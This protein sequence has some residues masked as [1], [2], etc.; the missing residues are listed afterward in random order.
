MNFYTPL[1]CRRGIGVLGLCIIGIMDLADSLR[2]LLVIDSNGKRYVLAKA[3]G[4]HDIGYALPGST[5][6]ADEQGFVHNAFPV[7]MAIEFLQSQCFIDAVCLEG[8]RLF[9]QLPFPFVQVRINIVFRQIGCLLA[10]NAYQGSCLGLG[11]KEGAT[12]ND[13][14]DG[15]T[16]EYFFPRPFMFLDAVAFA[17]ATAVVFHSLFSCFFFILQR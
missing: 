14:E 9:A 12:A 1:A 8:Q 7:E 4:L 11:S 17:I 15:Y 5:R 13:T 6:A 10:V 2:Q 3:Q 16:G